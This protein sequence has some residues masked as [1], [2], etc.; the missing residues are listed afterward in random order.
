VPA[1]KVR[2][3]IADSS[4]YGKDVG[5][6]ERF[7]QISLNQCSNWSRR[8]LGVEAHSSEDFRQGQPPW[9]DDRTTSNDNP[10][11]QRIAFPAIPEG[12]DAGHVDRYFTCL[13][14]LTGIGWIDH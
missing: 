7:K 11:Q 4:G 1:L 5:I 2:P 14:V 12:E 13:T 9:P 3:A 10:V 6:I 8:L